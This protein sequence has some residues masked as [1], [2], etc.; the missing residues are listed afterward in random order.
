MKLIDVVPRQKLMPLVMPDTLA[1]AVEDVSIYREM[2]FPVVEILC[3]RPSALEAIREVRRTMPDVFIGAGT[4][5]TIEQAEEAVAAGAQYLVSPGIDPVMLEFVQKH[6]LQ[7]IP[8]VAT[9]TD[10]AVGLRH[11]HLLQKFFPA[12]Q[13]GGTDYMNALASPYGHT[14]LKLVVGSGIEKHN[15]QEYLEHQLTA[16]V[17]ADW[18]INLRGETLRKELIVTRA[19]L[20]LK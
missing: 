4:I 19:L 17:I 20:G 14:P 6:N 12:R 16:A 9:P 13:L 7:F 3:R 8:G 18:V 15:Y 2:G 5:L 11:G 10:V 1:Q